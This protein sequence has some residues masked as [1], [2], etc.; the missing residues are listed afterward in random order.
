[1]VM[2]QLNFTHVY[3]SLWQTLIIHEHPDFVILHVPDLHYT[4]SLKQLIHCVALELLKF[5][6]ETDTVYIWT[7]SPSEQ[8]IVRCKVDLFN[9]SKASA[10]INPIYVTRQSSTSRGKA[11]FFIPPHST[12]SA[13]A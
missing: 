2:R 8:D 12:V 7:F 5:L 11:S 10:C 13:C 9:K 6:L 1:M 3:G 4:D